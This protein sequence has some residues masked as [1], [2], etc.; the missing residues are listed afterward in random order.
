MSTKINSRSP[1]FISYTEPVKPVVALTCT[2]INA[3]NFAVGVQGEITLPNIAYGSVISITSSSSDFANGKWAVVTSETTRSMTLRVL[4]PSG[5]SNADAYVDCTVTASQVVADCVNRITL[6]S[7]IPD[8]TLAVFGNSTTITLSNHFSISA[9]TLAYKFGQNSYA[10]FD[11]SLQS[12]VVTITTKTTAGVFPIVI[13]A[14]SSTDSTT[15]EVVD[16]FNVTVNNAGTFTCTTANLLGGDISS[17]GVLTLPNSVGTIT[18]TMETSGGNAVT[19]V[20]ANGGSGSISKTLFYAITVPT[21]YANAGA[22]VECSVAYTQTSNVVTPT[23]ACSM[24]DFDDQKITLA[25]DVIAGTLEDHNSFAS[26]TLDLTNFNFTPKKFAVVENNIDRDVTYSITV[27]SGYSN[28]GSTLSCVY[29]IL[30]PGD[31]TNIDCDSRTHSFWIGIKTPTGQDYINEY[32]DVNSHFGQANVYAD[33]SSVYQLQGKTLCLSAD[34]GD[35]K[36]SFLPPS[37]NLTVIGRTN[38]GTGGVSTVTVSEEFIIF[39]GSGGAISSMY[40]KNYANQTTVQ[41]F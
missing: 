5:F 36:G 6:S 3:T 30:Q 39:F 7:A 10:E 33:V 2:L 16:S 31:P 41:I 14:Y 37:G 11:L 27:P 32:T 20:A 22:S 29:E 13:V 12:G 34:G 4:V 21:G 26:G 9:G 38:Y 15:C 28:A 24:I 23:L 18:K 8:K 17:A 1:F 25:G 35:T 40:R 19:S